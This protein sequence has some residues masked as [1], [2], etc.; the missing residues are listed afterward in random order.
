MLYL[1][2]RKILRLL[3]GKKTCVRDDRPSSTAIGGI[4]AAMIIGFVVIL[5]LPDMVSGLYYIHKVR[6]KCKARNGKKTSH[7]GLTKV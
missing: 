7:N 3:Y 1:W 4:G 5:I 2:P 6:K